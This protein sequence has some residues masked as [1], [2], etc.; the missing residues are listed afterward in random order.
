MKPYYE[1]AGITIYCGDCREVLPQLPPVDLCL[2]D[3]PYGIGEYYAGWRD[4]EEN[5][6]ELIADFMPLVRKIATCTYINSGVGAAFLY[7][8]PDWIL[9]WFVRGA[10]ASGP[11]GFSCWQPLLA[12]GKD[13]YLRSGRGR[14]P[15]IIEGKLDDIVGSAELYDEHPCPKPLMLWRRILMRGSAAQT[16][17]ILDPFMGTGTTLVAAAD[18]HRSAIGIEI[19][20]KY[21]EISARRLEQEVFSFEPQ[22]NRRD[23]ELAKVQGETQALF[24]KDLL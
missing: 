21:C 16:D 10:T 13:L 5:L 9:S 1:H 2:T 11:F 14:R 4:T 3:P 22:N 7:P 6:V 19:E 18:Q 15:D 23:D 20:E 17:V 8:R 24:P 12:Y